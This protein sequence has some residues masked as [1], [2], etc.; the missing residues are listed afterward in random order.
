LY[1]VGGDE[2]EREEVGMVIATI[3]STLF[4]PLPAPLSPP[5]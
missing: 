4:T 3:Y 1:S 2:R 5:H